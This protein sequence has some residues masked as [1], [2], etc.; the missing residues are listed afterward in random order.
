MKTVSAYGLIILLLTAWPLS[1]ASKEAPSTNMTILYTN[2]TNGILSACPS[3]PARLL[4][5]LARRATVIHSYRRK[6]P[7]LR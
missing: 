1:S 7:G 3:C 2:N 4:G 6:K 5:G